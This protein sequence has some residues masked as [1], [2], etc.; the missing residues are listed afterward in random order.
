MFFNL[1]WKFRYY[2]LLDKVNDINDIYHDKNFLMKLITLGSTITE[3]EVGA[4][5]NSSSNVI[6]E[7]SFA[8]AERWTTHLKSIQK[9]IVNDVFVSQP[10]YPKNKVTLEDYLVNDKDYRI[11]AYSAF[12]IIGSSLISLHDTIAPYPSTRQEYLY[13][14]NRELFQDGL[15][16]YL[17]ILELYAG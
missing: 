12:K 2:R 7:T 11:D 13:K 1:F 15:T 4:L 9:Q 14:Q 17:K 10:I 3:S 5:V 6:I 8:N 16:F